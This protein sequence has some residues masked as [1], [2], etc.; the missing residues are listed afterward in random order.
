MTR[1]GVG[2]DGRRGGAFVG[3]REELAELD[4]RAGSAL[5]GRPTVVVV[6]G[7]AG[8]GKSALVREWLARGQARRFHVLRA[9]CDRSET[10]LPFGVVGQLVS[11][12]PAALLRGL[13]LLAAPTPADTAPFQAA[14]QLLELLDRLRGPV[15]LVVDDLQWADRASAQALRFALRQL[16][17]EE[18]LSV[19]VVRTGAGEA[20]SPADAD[21]QELSGCLA[22]LDGTPG[23]VAL[24]TLDGLTPTDVADLVLRAGGRPV[25][26]ATAERLCEHTHGHPLY[27]QSVIAEAA[28]Q[29]G[30]RQEPLPVPA[31]MT[32]MVARLLTGA[33]EPTRALVE[34]AAVLDSRTPLDTV[35]RV[36]DVPDP[37]AAVGPALTAGLLQWWPDEPGTPVA[38]PC[39][40]HRHAVLTGM[41]PGRLRALHTAAAPLVG[42]AAAWAHRVAAAEGPDDGLAAEL[43]AEAN[44][45]LG[46][47]NAERAATL[48]LWAADVCGTRAERE[49]HV[50]TAALHLLG[51]D[52][53]TR[54]QQLLP[55]VDSCAASPLRDVVLGGFA[56]SRGALADAETRLTSALRAA[57]DA[58]ASDAA[59]RTAAMAGAW[60][61]RL[62]LIL[63]RGDETVR[64][65]R[66]MPPAAALDPPLAYHVRFNRAIGLAYCEG[67]EA[68]AGELGDLPDSAADVAPA[69]ADL[70]TA[71]GQLRV[72]AGR[73][74]AGIDDLSTTL[75]LIPDKTRPLLAEGLY[76]TLALAHH[77]VGEWDDATIS[78]EKGLGIAASEDRPWALPFGQAI[79]SHVLAD[80]GEWDRAEE[81]L[82]RAAGEE[83]RVPGSALPTVVVG[84]ATF[85]RA[86]NDPRGML[87]ALE[88]LRDAPR[89]GSVSVT[90]V[91]WRPLLVEALLGVGRVEDADRALKDL[92]PLADTTP[93]LGTVTAWLSGRV[94]EAYGHRDEALARYGAGVRLPVTRDD[95]PLHR[96]LLEQAYGKALAGG[97]PRK[98]ALMWLGRARDRFLALGARPYLDRC[99]RDLAAVSPA[100][101][102]RQRGGALHLSGHE[103]EVAHLVGRG[104]TNKEIAAEL[105]L[106]VK[107]VEYHLG[108]V[109][110]R[111]G[112]RGRRELRARVQG[113]TPEPSPSG[114]GPG[115]AAGP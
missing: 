115:A 114:R 97:Q 93:C 95:V 19:L 68:G 45:L 102:L 32:A 7:P 14:R 107:T 75:T 33:A 2:A 111:L 23:G 99:E 76:P 51:A 3:R 16:R 63:G 11:G 58:P 100:A 40:G 112:I 113:V 67:P 54:L 73:F 12:L 41:S 29:L 59:R 43:E 5:S 61:G 92:A 70:L 8:I 55:R 25:S 13:H 26:A 65:C 101:A 108:N 39:A 56:A 98:E 27:L 52:R 105:F 36:A 66:E 10:D 4:A 15:V 86:R 85:A 50:L 87:A 78:A 28:G 47:G 42:R 72:W 30:D 20:A 110:R 89:T 106:S 18:V 91:W 104:M 37:A 60:L 94:A 48:L 80:R 64:V 103:R 38:V 81:L 83:R 21:D 109:Y 31:S 77:Q 62:Y 9:L 22:D 1:N 35:A 44:R 57:R 49:R 79:L 71:R 69:D 82:D 88:R 96:A 17:A 6:R 24:I 53:F 84:A 90:Q 74:R 34:A 46:L